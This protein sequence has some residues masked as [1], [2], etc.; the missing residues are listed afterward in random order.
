MSLFYKFL[1]GVVCTSLLGSPYFGFSVKAD[2]GTEVSFTQNLAVNNSNSA[3]AD[4]EREYEL[5]VSPV[6]DDDILSVQA[7][8]QAEAIRGIEG[9]VILDSD[10]IIIEGTVSENSEEIFCNDIE[11]IINTDVFT[12]PGIYRYCL[13]SNSED[14]EEISYFDECSILYE[15]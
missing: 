8:N 9:G 4:F 14:Y 12:N 7:Q 15:T 13:T 3:S 6:T 11:L 10:S 2:P 5:S 1:T